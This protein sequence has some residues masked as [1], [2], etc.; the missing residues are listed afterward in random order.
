VDL[1]NRRDPRSS[2]FD[3]QWATLRAGALQE[4]TNRLS[5]AFH[6]I[7]DDPAFQAAYLDWKTS[8]LADLVPALLAKEAT[9]V[10]AVAATAL[11]KFPSARLVAGGEAIISAATN[12][13]ETMANARQNILDFV[14][15]APIISLEYTD[16]LGQTSNL[17]LIVETTPFKGGSFTVNGSATEAARRL[18]SAQISAQ[19]DIPIKSTAALGNVLMSFAGEFQ[20][21]TSPVPG[22][23]G[24]V[25]ATLTIPISN[26]GVSIPFSISWANRTELIQENDVRGSVGLSFNLDTLIGLAKQ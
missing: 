20:H 8:L 23:L 25:Q 2:R 14:G 17:K 10:S 19:L 4:M 22:N 16:N 6:Q 13:T 24:L 3:A 1:L 12:A 5:A 26:T 21:I 7:F 9:Q 11:D 15:A 18:Q